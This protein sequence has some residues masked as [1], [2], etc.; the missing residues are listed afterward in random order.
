MSEEIKL[1]NEQ[2]NFIKEALKGSNILVDACIGSG[3]TTSIQQLCNR[4]PKDKNILYLTYNKLLKIDAKSKI[5]SPNTFVTNYHGFAW[6]ML[7]RMHAQKP[8]ISD[9]IQSFNDYQPA[10]P[11][12]DVLIIDEYQDI[13]LELAE[14][15]YYIKESCPGIQIIAVGDM[16]QKIYDKTTLAVKPFIESFL[17]NH[18]KLTFSYCFRLNK[19]YAGMIGQIWNKPIYGTNEEL[20]VEILTTEKILDVLSGERPEDILC[21]GARTG[22]LPDMLNILET[23][24]PEKFNKNTVYASIR[25]QDS[26]GKANPTEKNAIFTTYDSSKGLERNICVIFD[27]QP[28]Y[29][30][31]RVNKPGQKADI[32]RNI[33]CVAMSR[34]KKRI[35]FAQN[36][37]G[38]QILD[39]LTLCS[40]ETQ[41][42]A[43]DNQNIS[44]MFDFKYKEDIED[45]YNMLDIKE[46]PMEDRSLINVK[47]HDGLIDLSPCVGIYQEAVYFNGFDIRK[48][49]D[50]FN[51]VNRDIQIKFDEN[52]T[53]EEQIL[54]LIAYNTRQNRYVDQVKPEFVTE[55]QKQ[56]I[57]D[58]L[59]TQLSRNEEEQ[60]GCGIDV[61]SWKDNGDLHE[62][63]MIGYADVIKGKTVYE[64]KFVSEITHEHI[65]QCACYMA[66]QNLKRGIV[67]NIYDNKM[68]LVNL[69]N[70]NK[71]IKQVV[72]TVSKGEITN[73]IISYRNEARVKKDQKNEHGAKRGRKAARK[74]DRANEIKYPRL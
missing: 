51:E 16:D 9:I 40:V 42:T 32:L 4:M 36:T 28:S 23:T 55:E 26:Y 5:H 43:I 47:T 38:E 64:L 65:L 62:F 54:Q 44:E 1:T 21:L 25:E 13:E 46:I 15:L 31:T 10:L 69:K 30:E 50:L 56:K 12:Y 33:F 48:Q 27:F 39:P 52:K 70:R 49:Y 22:D 2:E 67:W 29:W 74:R 8:G 53:I 24:H 41:H 18:T 19:D 35:I 57:T 71:F 61:A 73:C 72:N 37:G 66:A 20:S 11:K 34:G 60:I 7:M 3:K 14:M 45:C 68:L 59:S 58:R 6:T 17:G 63:S